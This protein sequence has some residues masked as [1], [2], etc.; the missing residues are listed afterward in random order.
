MKQ[1]KKIPTVRNVVLVSAL[2]CVALSASC[3]DAGMVGFDVPTGGSDSGVVTG[4]TGVVVA[5]VDVPTIRPDVP[6][7]LRCSNNMQC[8]DRVDCTPGRNS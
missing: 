1:T 4:D 8:D 7:P 3:T 5:P 2:A 6:N